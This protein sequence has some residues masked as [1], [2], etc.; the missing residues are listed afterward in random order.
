M[1][2]RGAARNLRPSGI[3]SSLLKNALVCF[4]DGLIVVVVG[5]LD[6]MREIVEPF[7]ASF[8]DALI[9]FIDALRKSME[10]PA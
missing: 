10:S 2:D 1:I 8:A 7:D 6:V 4:E 9:A 3:S 5:K